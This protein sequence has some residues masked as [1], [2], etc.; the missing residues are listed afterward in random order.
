[1]QLGIRRHELVIPAEAGMTV[2]AT[3]SHSN[4]HEFAYAT[5]G[6]NPENARVRRGLMCDLFA[7]SAATNYSAPKSLPIFAAKAA[8]NMDGWALVLQEES[9]LRGEI[10]LTRLL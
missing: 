8:R 2:M 1:M 4:I 6:L 5:P 3:C 10:G 9:G 7:L